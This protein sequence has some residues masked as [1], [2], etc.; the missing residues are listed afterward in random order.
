[1]CSIE[2]CELILES[3]RV[4][5]PRNTSVKRENNLL[6]STIVKRFLSF[7]KLPSCESH[8]SQAACVVALG[9]YRK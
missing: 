1:M 8:C 7:P 9:L 2:A 3:S 5:V 4:L 6:H